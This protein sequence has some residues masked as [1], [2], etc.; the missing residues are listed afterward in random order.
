M[1]QG[2]RWTGR[3][4]GT[5]LLRELSQALLLGRAIGT[6]A[7]FVLLSLLLGCQ[8]SSVAPAI[9]DATPA[10]A[11]APAPQANRFKGPLPA[12]AFTVADMEV[13]IYGGELVMASP[14]DPKTFNPLLGNESSSN[15]VLR[16]MFSECWSYNNGRQ[17]EEPGLCSSYTRS[18]D[19]LTYVFT[20]RDGVRWSDG[21]PITT[22]D[23]EFSYRVL[24]DPTIPN[25][26]RDLFSQGSDDRG[27]ARYPTF[28]KLDTRRFQFKFH[29]PDVLF[30]YTGGSFAIM[31]KHRWTQAY[32][33]GRFRN[34]MN[35][36]MN[37]DDLVGSGPFIV[38]RYEPGQRVVMSRNPYYWK[39]N[40]DGGRL[41]YLD[42]ITFLIVPDQ[43]AALQRF[44][45]G[46]THMHEVRAADYHRLK[47]REKTS[48][49][50]V[51]DLGPSFNTN[52]LMLNLDQRKSEWST[53][54]RSSQIRLV[55]AQELPQSHQSCHR[56]PV[57]R[58]K[59]NGWPRPAALGLY[60][61]RKP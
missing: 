6:G 14:G 47:R 13:G 23:V 16:P 21:E 60:Q 57:D 53:L 19:G 30:H 4:G 17:E 27:K 35:V 10:E 32:R 50:R 18:E 26:D 59:C 48:D 54:R 39:I 25:S 45:A 20:L 58:E 36:G 3:W 44:E 56:S 24:M 46:E 28:T 2:V 7:C 12:E 1:D 5:T 52:Y 43:G 51:V 55:Q 41:P 9:P 34:V 11:T 8:K 38:S 37:L 15:A 40:T 22:A 49:F 31:P 61:S 33:E 29:R 42:Q